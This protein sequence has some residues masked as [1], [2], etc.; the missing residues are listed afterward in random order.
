MAKDP[1]AQEFRADKNQVMSSLDMM[2]DML[3]QCIATGM[4]D[5][6]S[7]IYNLLLELTD[8]ADA[9]SSYLELA[10]VMNKA[11]KIEHNLETWLASSGFV[12]QGLE[13]PKIE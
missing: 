1:R 12:T 5:Y 6:E 3:A 7:G 11:Q 10:E 9:A 13:W 4:A 2:K 8:E